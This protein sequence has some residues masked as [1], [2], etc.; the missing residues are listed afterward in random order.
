MARSNPFL[1]LLIAGSLTLSACGP[2]E[3][4]TAIGK[5]VGVDLG[6]IPDV[7]VIPYSSPDLDF[8]GRRILH[9][10]LPYD[11]LVQIYVLPTGNLETCFITKSPISANLGSFETE[12]TTGIGGFDF[13]V[14][15]GEVSKGWAWYASADAA[16]ETSGDVWVDSEPGRVRVDFEGPFMVEAFQVRIDGSQNPIDV[17]G[18]TG[19]QQDR[20]EVRI[21][22]PE[23]PQL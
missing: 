12:R 21:S 15:D 17:E 6:N 14:M 19:L 22:P 20:I 8:P 9:E 11:L 13:C 10:N 23:W 7:P 4:N 2:R 3:A 1:S 16:P 5:R 18:I